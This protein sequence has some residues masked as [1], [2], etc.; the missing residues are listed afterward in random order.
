VFPTLYHFFNYSFGISLGWLQVVNT[1]GFFVA[2]SIAA[3]FRVMQLEMSRKTNL[4]LLPYT[5]VTT[6]IGKPIPIFDHVFNGVLAFLFG[7]KVIWLAANAGPDFLPQEHIFNAEGSWVFGLISAAIVM[8]FRYRADLKQRLSEPKSEVVKMDASYHMGTITTIALI[9]GFLGAKIFHILEDPSHLQW[10]TIVSEIFSSGGWTFY[11]GL[12]CGAG[13]VLIYCYRKGLNLLHILDSGGPA[14]MLSYGLGRFGCHFSGDGDWGIANT[15]PK[16]FAAMPDWAWAYT[17]PHNVLGTG[18]Y[19]PADMVQV[20]GFTGDYAYQLMIPV[21]PTPLYEAL[22][23]VALFFIMWK[24]FR[25]KNLP[26]GNMFALYLIFAGVE[27]FA[28]ES[29]REHG[30]SLYHIGSTSFSQA[31]MISIF[32]VFIGALWMFLLGKKL[33]P[34][35]G[36]KSTI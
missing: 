30:T 16:P 15:R 9:S 20:P 11:G 35:F 28:I 14:M 24:V 36:V 2:I 34:L 29:I 23:G 3:A 7:Y 26:A 17:Y 13:G 25:M 1:F 27:R 33:R 12:I 18:N 22:M 19:P 4:G 21:Y 8:A 10:S 6:I 31:Q 32:L 5:D